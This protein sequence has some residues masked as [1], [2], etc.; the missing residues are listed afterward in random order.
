MPAVPEQHTSAPVSWRPLVAAC[1]GTFLLMIY[2]TIVTVALPNVGADLG[3]GF[4]GLQWI[5]DVFTVALAGLLLG[6][7]SLSD[8]LGRKRVYLTGLVAFG[9]ATLVCGLADSVAVLIAARAG[10]GIAGAAMF[11]TILP[12]VG[13]TYHGHARAKAFAIWGTVAGVAGAVGTVAGG[14]LAELLGWRWIFFASLPIWAVALILGATTLTESVRTGNR[15]D[16]P[17]I[18]AFTLSATALTYAVIDGGDHGWTAPGAVIALVVAVVCVV[19]FV[20]VQ[21]RSRT[22]MVPL[23]LFGTPAFIGVLVVAFGYYFASFGA[24][25]VL[26]LWLQGTA[27]LSPLDTSLVLTVQIVVFFLVSAL[28]S[29][30]L[31][32]LAPSIALGGATVLIGLGCATATVVLADPSWVALLPALVITGIGAGMV[33]PVFPAVAIAAVPPAYGGTAGAAANSSRQL[34]LALGIALCGTIYRGQG[35]QTTSGIVAAM[36]FCASLAVL[37]GLVAG[38]LLRRPHKPASKVSSGQDVT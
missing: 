29:K 8:N 7:G 31:H 32:G 36:V 35:Q 14:V 23:K 13:L 34:G 22:P 9:L 37:S 5:V 11:A 16:V 1:L 27:G 30:R 33:S 12:L 20:V 6:M 3:G 17:G 25:P 21:R 19:V 26:S 18:A 15:I 2:T 10:Q 38:A 24:L 28:I 4:T